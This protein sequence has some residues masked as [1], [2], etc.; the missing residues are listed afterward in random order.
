[1]ENNSLSE[2][3]SSLRGLALLAIFFGGSI[4]VHE[5]G[6]FLA[7]RWRKLKIERF[8]IGFGPKIFGWT[9]K[10]GV[11]YRV[12]WIPLGGYVALPQMGDNSSIEG[13]TEEK[14]EKLP[15]ISYADKMIVAVMGAVFNVIFAF[16]LAIILSFTGVPVPEGSGSTVVGYVQEKIP[17]SANQLSELG[18]GQMIPGPAFVA[19]IK[20]GDKII[21][22]DDNPVSTFSQVSEAVLL[23]NGKNSQ[24]EPTCRFTILRDN[25]EQTIIVQPA[26]VELNARSG[27]RIR[28]A[29]LMSRNTVVLDKPLAG[30]PADLAG[31]VAGDR[32]VSVDG[33]TIYNTAQLQ[34]I[35][36][37]GGATQRTVEVE[38][39]QGENKGAKR[40]VKLTPQM[41]TLTNP[42][43]VITY[44]ENQKQNSI[45]LVPVTAN[46]VPAD[47]QTPRNQLMVLGVFPEDASR[48]E[49]LKTSTVFDKIDGKELTILRSLEDLEKATNAGPQNLTFYWKRAN[50]ENGSVILKNAEIKPGQPLERA[51]IGAQFLSVPETAFYNPFQTCARI[52]SQTFTTLG[53]L[54]DRNS[55]IKVNQLASVISISKTYYHIS[56]DL[57]RVLWFTVLIN[58][59]LAVLNLMPIPVLDGGHMLIATLNR[60][61]KGGL[62]TRAVT[63]VQFACMAMLFG[64]MAYIILNDVRRCTGDNEMQLKQQ[65][66]SRH[67]L[68]PVNFTESK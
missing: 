68:R 64:L 54:F 27:D 13:E 24:G 9:G 66:I 49:L 33:Q 65:I 62:N 43:A 44:G 4:F 30:S 60:F 17:T 5:L 8:S 39:T 59:N 45:V 21:A 51:L 34:E 3:L 61:I 2:L 22:V 26:R 48:A 29:G 63:I 15:E 32:F 41:K 1:M 18:L 11:D 55:D 42:V 50:G 53:R 23:G 52:I 25:Q 38:S 31:L 56:D 67:V 37:S 14:A 7:A 6:H 28:V 58:L 16:G 19:G 12:S 47:A 10:D 35:L 20:S 40:T 36:R 46:L 57:R